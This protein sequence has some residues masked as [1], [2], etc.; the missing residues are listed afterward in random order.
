MRLIGWAEI[1]I[2]EM[3]R[4]R[5]EKI[6]ADQRHGS[7]IAAAVLA[8]IDDD[9]LG[10]GQKIHRRRSR[11]SRE[12]RRHKSVQLQVADVPRHSLDSFE[13]EVDARA[14]SP[15]L[16]HLFWRWFPIRLFRRYH[17]GRIH[18]AQMLVVANRPQ[19][20]SKRLSKL[21]GAGDGVVVLALLALADGL[22]S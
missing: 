3:H 20:V 8:Q 5:R 16:F 18:Y 12:C 22:R 13:P 11:V 4:L 1:K 17:L 14:E 2:V 15:F 9:R 7:W 10:I 21:A 6:T 19:V